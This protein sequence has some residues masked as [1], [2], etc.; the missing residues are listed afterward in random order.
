M[1]SRVPRDKIT[2]PSIPAAVLARSPDRVTVDTCQI[3]VAR[4]GRARTR[5]SVEALDNNGRLNEALGRFSRTHRRAF[6]PLVKR[7]YAKWSSRPSLSFSS[8]SLPL[9]YRH[10]YIKPVR[11]PCMRSDGTR[12]A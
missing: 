9:S 5:R 8:L 2:T 11:E 7:M 12:D 6:L 1:A 10:A 4:A 3:L